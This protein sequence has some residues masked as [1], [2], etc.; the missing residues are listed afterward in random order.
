MWV[1][2]VAHLLRTCEDLFL[3]DSTTG[4]YTYCIVLKKKV[5]TGTQKTLEVDKQDI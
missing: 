2:R 1:F 4:F 5:L 3:K